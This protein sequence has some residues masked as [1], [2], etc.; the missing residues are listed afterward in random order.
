MKKT[1]AL[2]VLF[3]MCFSLFSCTAFVEKQLENN[4]LAFAGEKQETSY[5]DFRDES[6]LAFLEKIQKFSSRLT[7]KTAMEYGDEGN[8]AISP[9]SIYM[10]LSLACECAEGETRKEILDAVGVTYEEVNEYAG[11]LY[12]YANKEYLQR[13]VLGDNNVVAFQNLSNS[14]WLADEISFI[15]D[16]VNKLSKEYNC[17]VFRVSYI[18]GEAQYLINKYIELKT[19]GL[20][21]GNVDLSPE[22]YFVLM[23]TYYLKEVWNVYGK[24]LSFTSN[25]YTFKNGDGTSKKINL[26]EGY[27]NDG[28]VY[29]AEDY[30]CFFTSTEHGF[31]LYFFLPNEGVNVSSIL[32]AENIDAALTEKKWEHV[33]D[34]NLQLHYTR[35]LFPEFKAEFDKDISNIL[36]NEFSINDLFDPYSCSMSN[37]SSDSLYCEGVFHKVSLTVD[38]TGIE[39]AAVTYLPVA[40]SAGPPPYEKVY[41][42]FIVDGAFGFVLCD[43]YGT[44]V[45]SGVINT[46]K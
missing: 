39:G 7:E 21:K 41:H 13:G 27:Y 44:I 32:T 5:E 1:I 22:T 45:F 15:D 38:K 24:N 16:G 23:N 2:L 4:V 28:K 29:N 18:T 19:N 30:S 35:V 42:D 10:A 8:I 36:K 33:D 25:K 20:I 12:A 34:E 17:D 3:A 26:L 43:Q 37:I 46:I 40:G 11:K 14:I 31:K 9:I 6:Y